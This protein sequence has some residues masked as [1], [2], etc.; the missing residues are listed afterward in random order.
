MNG[1]FPAQ[2]VHNISWVDSVYMAWYCFKA[3]KQKG[4]GQFTQFAGESSSKSESDT[5]C[6][7]PA[8]T[9]KIK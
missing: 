4:T 2:K 9:I 7:N 6:V 3:N 1:K 8:W 5:F